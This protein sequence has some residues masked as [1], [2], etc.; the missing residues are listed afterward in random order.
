MRILLLHDYGTL[1]G[2]GEVMITS[3]R[4][5]LRARGHDALLFTS[6]ARPLPLPIIA[7]AVCFGTVSPLRRVLQTM[8]LHA[9]LRLRQLL[10]S[11]RP[12]I[13]HVKMFL[14]QLSP[15]ILP[16]L[17]P[18]PS[19]L[20]VINYNLVCP[21]NTKMLPNGSPCHFTPGF[22]CHAMGCI[23]WPGVARTLVQRRLTDL[24]V[25]NRIVAN[26]RWVADRLTVEGIRVDGW[27]D[28]GVPIRAQRSAL[29]V[30]HLVG[31]AGR[32]IQKK[33]VDVLLKAMAILLKR[34]PS[35][36]LVI[37]GDGPE[38]AKL[39]RLADHLGIR[40]NVN[41]LGHL[42]QEAMEQ[43]LAPAWVQAIPSIW[44][45][46]FGLVVAEAMMRGTAVVTSNIG[47]PVEQIT[48]GKTGFVVAPGDP[49]ALAE[50]LELVL[51]NRN[52]AEQM[53]NAGRR[54][55]LDSLTVDRHA[56]RILAIY[57]EVLASVFRL[58]S[59]PT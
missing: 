55:A 37:A 30:D 33:G 21:I 26:S 45:E 39:E 11:F 27:V 53:G 13:V 3:L 9:V 40:P 7:D 10:R 47:G 25:F 58:P 32:L 54:Y 14:T 43:A 35:A 20:H 52:R 1:N 18:I 29:G 42:N 2:G 51:S 50:A 46:P 36:R 56:T 28:N 16:L 5:C 22:V 19:I 57:K 44:E 31:F 17:R 4:D 38:R 24:S 15:I 59:T 23:S 12:E 41:F 34:L 6:T 48:P 8:N 49:F